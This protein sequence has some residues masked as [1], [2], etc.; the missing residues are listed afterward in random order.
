MSSWIRCADQPAVFLELLLA[1][2][3]DADASLVPRQV[4]PHPLEPRHRVFELRQLDLKVRLVGPRVGG[5]DIED[6][7]GA[8][9]DLDVELLLEVA[10]LG[11]AQVVVEDDHV[12]LLGLDEHP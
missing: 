6:H 2:P 9:D 4:G 1:R 7:L 12:G 8:V 3:P 10:G 11:G 5:E